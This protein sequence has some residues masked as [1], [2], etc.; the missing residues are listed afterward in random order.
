MKST[1]QVKIYSGKRKWYE[2]L[3]AS[4]FYAVTVYTLLLFL[5]YSTIGYNGREA[6]IKFVEFLYY[7]APSLSMAL[8]FSVTK[9]I[10][11]VVDS[12]LILSYYKV[13]PFC[14]V[15]KTPALVFEY[16]SI[17]SQEKGIYQT[18]LWYKGNKFYKMYE[19]EN[20]EDA[21]E[22]GRMLSLK[23]GIDLLDAT[24]KGNFK[25]IDISDSL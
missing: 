9:D 17:F 2:L 1:N 24:Q 8:L 11:I 3:L 21:F 15:K 20:K 5:F 22:F 12:G 7:G 19:F 16:I 6:L 4:I 14:K 18:N 25:W 10:E 23:L 13:G